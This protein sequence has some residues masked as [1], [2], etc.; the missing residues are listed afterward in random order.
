MQQV[1]HQTFGPGAIVLMD[2]KYFTRCKFD[3]CAI[4]FSGGD[5]GWMDCSFGQVQI[6]FTGAAERVMLFARNFGLVPEPSKQPT[7]QGIP[8]SSKGEH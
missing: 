7:P 4:V 1:D 2:D 6:S 5:F 3:G 8:G